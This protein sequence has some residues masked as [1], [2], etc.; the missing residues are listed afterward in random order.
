MSQPEG[1]KIAVLE[2]NM[3]ILKND[4]SEIKGDIKLIMGKLDNQNILES[5]IS[6]NTLQIQKLNNEFSKRLWVA[7]SLS[8]IL[9]AIMTF[10]IISFLNTV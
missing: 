8:A 6:N 7:S 4:V 5:R 10:L 2:S 3:E 9:G 1:E